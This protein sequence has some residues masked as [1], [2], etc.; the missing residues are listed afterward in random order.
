MTLVTRARRVG[1]QTPADIEYQVEP[2]LKLSASV[3][4]SYEPVSMATQKSTPW[5]GKQKNILQQEEYVVFKG[6]IYVRELMSPRFIAKSKRDNIWL[7]NMYESIWLNRKILEPSLRF[8]I[9][10]FME[11]KQ[12]SLAYADE[13][14]CHQSYLW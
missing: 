4:L 12:V 3:L 8:G 10:W 2:R 13:Y 5:P 7:D 9:K 14:K 1:E 11:W 6:V